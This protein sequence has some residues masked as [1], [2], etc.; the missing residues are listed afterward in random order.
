MVERPKFPKNLTEASKMRRE[1]GKVSYFLDMYV[2]NP[3]YIGKLAELAETPQFVAQYPDHHV[4]AIDEEILGATPRS[5]ENDDQ[6]QKYKTADD[7]LNR[8]F[9]ERGITKWNCAVIQTGPRRAIRLAIEGQP[10]V[11]IEIS[12]P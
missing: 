9:D 11:F 2:G 4:V 3:D 7:A 8:V 6:E 5:R 12:S 1:V 10:G